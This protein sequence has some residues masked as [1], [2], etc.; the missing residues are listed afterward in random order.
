MHDSV[1]NICVR[2]AETFGDEESIAVLVWKKADVM[3]CGESMAITDEEAERVLSGIGD[4]EYHCRYGIDRESVR[5]R[6][7]YL[8]EEEEQSREVSVPA[9]ALAQV[10]RVAG[11]YMRLEDA[12]GGEGRSRV[13]W[14]QE[15]EAIRRVRDALKA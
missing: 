7:A 8:R 5:D 4:E 11:D 3:D 9:A 13:L 10:L 1:K 2:L 14:P 6:L 15:C 12:Q